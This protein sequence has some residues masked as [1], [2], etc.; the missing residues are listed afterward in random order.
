V[1]WYQ[2]AKQQQLVLLFEFGLLVQPTRQLHT[3]KAIFWTNCHWSPSRADECLNGTLLEQHKCHGRDAGER[4]HQ[5]YI[6]VSYYEAK[7]GPKYEEPRRLSPHL[8]EGQ[9]IVCVRQLREERRAAKAAAAASARIVLRK[10]TEWMRRQPKARS[11]K[12]AARVRQFYELTAAARDVPQ[13]E[14]NVAFEGGVGMRRQVRSH[15]AYML[16]VCFSAGDALPVCTC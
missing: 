15:A 11:V 3:T 8:V 4:E 9:R 14:T 6:A 16:A 7:H 12:A 5:Y 1:N 2:Q 10:E 13:A